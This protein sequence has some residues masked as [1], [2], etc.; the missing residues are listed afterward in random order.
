M[1]W[2]SMTS[3]SNGMEPLPTCNIHIHLQYIMA[4]VLSTRQ[5]LYVIRRSFCVLSLS[6]VTL[7]VI[8]KKLCYRHKHALYFSWHTSLTTLV[9]IY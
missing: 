2:H 9:S 7:S 8:Y 3:K 6:S 4:V 5:Y 1:P